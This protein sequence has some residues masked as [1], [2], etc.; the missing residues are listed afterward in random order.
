MHDGLG[1]VHGVLRADHDVAELALADGRP[2]AV[3]GERE[4]VGRPALAAVLGV[5]RGDLVRA[6]EVDGD[7]AV[8][9]ARGRGGEQA[10]MPH[11]LGVERAAEHVDL[12]RRHAGRRLSAG[13]SPGAWREACSS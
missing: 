4:H 6:D 10:G 5:E 12:Q 13:R 9:H 3:D 11:P 8:L 1:E 7:V 2:V